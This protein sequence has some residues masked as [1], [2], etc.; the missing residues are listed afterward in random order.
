MLTSC[1]FEVVLIDESRIGYLV[2]VNKS[3]NAS[4]MN[5][6]TRKDGVKEG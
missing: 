5:A 4:Q 2:K 1:S 3:E 6:E